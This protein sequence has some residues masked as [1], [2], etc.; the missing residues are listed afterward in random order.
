MKNKYDKY[1]FFTVGERIQN[2]MPDTPE[3][4]KTIF[5]MNIFEYILYKVKKFINNENRIK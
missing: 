3:G 1:I 4:F 5:Q 2:Q